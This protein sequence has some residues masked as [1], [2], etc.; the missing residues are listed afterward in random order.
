[1][2]MPAVAPMP[3]EVAGCL[4]GKPGLYGRYVIASGPYMIEGSDN[5]TPARARR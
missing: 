5:L 1:M 2:T 3:K 4:T